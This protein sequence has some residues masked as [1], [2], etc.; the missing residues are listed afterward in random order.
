MLDLAGV[1]E[2]FA[3]GSR[4]AMLDQLM[5]GESLP[6]GVLAANAGIAPSTAS[7]HIAKLEAGGLVKVATRGR[8]REVSIAGA[9]VAD[10]IEAIGRLAEPT[11]ARSLRGVN[12]MESLRLARSCYDHLAGAAGVALTDALI[13]HDALQWQGDAL[14]ARDSLA[15]K[16]L[17]IDLN[18]VRDSAG[19]RM[20]VRPCLDWT[21]RR[22]HFAGALGAASLQTM[23]ETGWVRRKPGGRA[24]DITRA[25]AAGFAKLG[26][27]FG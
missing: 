17:N 23:I 13:K 3:D 19:R 26:A 14:V 12:R 21:E 5:N 18:A 22:P 2:L 1:A 20:L 9:D 8:V 25:G 15:W 27:D 7:K 10:A 11:R 4:A 16:S 24:L 6:V